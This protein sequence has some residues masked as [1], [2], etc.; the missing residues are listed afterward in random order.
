MSSV[1]LNLNRF[2]ELH[3]YNVH[4][5]SKIFYNINDNKRK[6]KYNSIIYNVIYK[7]IIIL[8]YVF[9]YISL[10]NII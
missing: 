9:I 2:G 3:K 4:I 7:I 10:I 6:Y 5:Q 1:K 8:K